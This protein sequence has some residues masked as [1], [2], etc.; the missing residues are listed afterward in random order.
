VCSGCAVAVNCLRRESD[1]LAC[2]ECSSEDERARGSV[3]TRSTPTQQHL[4][5]LSGT[6]AYPQEL[7][8]SQRKTKASMAMK[9]KKEKE[10]GEVER[11]E[12]MT[13]T[14]RRKTAPED[15]EVERVHRGRAMCMRQSPTAPAHPPAVRCVC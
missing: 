8:N 12:R 2:R 7:I 3:R 11:L 13:S 14:K 4:E 9:R 6:H 5:S 1:A 15:G 10:T